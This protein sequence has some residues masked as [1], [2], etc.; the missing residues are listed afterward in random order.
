MA[1]I[2]RRGVRTMGQ[3]FNVSDNIGFDGS[4]FFCRRCGKAGYERATQVRGHLAMCPGTLMR[5]GVE[6]TTSSNQLQPLASGYNGG[7]SGS[8]LL[9]PLVVAG[10][11]TNPVDGPVD[12]RYEQLAGRVTQMENHYNHVLQTVNQPQY[13][14]A[15]AKQDFFSQYKGILILGAV[16]LFALIL[17]E[18]SNNCPAT[19]DGKSSKAADIGTKALGK[20]LDTSITKGVSALFK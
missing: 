7:L 11:V 10:P 12:S 17:S 13:Q 4:S 2:P 3:A 18:R 8:Q 6:P 1:D 9:Q 14:P 20:L 5:K 19:S 16:I 15:T